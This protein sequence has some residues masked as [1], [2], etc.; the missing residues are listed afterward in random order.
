MAGRRKRSPAAPAAAA[1]DER[2]AAIWRVV[3]AVP[4]G[5]V[6]TYGG[7]ATRAGLPGRA[8]LVGRVLKLAPDTLALP[9]HRV[10]AAGGRIALPP[11][12]AAFREQRR[13]LAAEGVA[14]V[15]GRVRLPQAAD[16]DALLWG[17]D[18]C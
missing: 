1:P 9:W 2:L 7:V 15:R 12:S 18:G 13:R 17:A 16:L 5:T 8:R 4:R 3:A 14:V 6:V 10:V 11:R